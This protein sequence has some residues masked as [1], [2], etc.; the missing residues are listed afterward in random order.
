MKFN[1]RERQRNRVEDRIIRRLDG[2]REPI[3][4]SEG[5][6]ITILEMIAH[7]A[8]MTGRAIQVGKVFNGKT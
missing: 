3:C 6:F 2:T 4:K 8:A 5:P 7:K 1:D